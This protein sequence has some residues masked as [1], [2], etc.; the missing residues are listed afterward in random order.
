MFEDENSG[1]RFLVHPDWRSLVQPSDAK[2]ISE[3]LVDFLERADDQP[4]VLLEQL[5][6]LGIGLLVTQQAGES[7][8]D[9]PKLSELVPQFVQL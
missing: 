3:L 7:I 8:S 2:I 4:A 9:Y 5:S 6:S 1:L